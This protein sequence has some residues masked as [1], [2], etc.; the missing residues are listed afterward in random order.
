MARRNLRIQEFDVST[1]SNGASRVLCGQLGCRSFQV[2]AG[3]DDAMQ[4][5]LWK[6]SKPESLLSLPGHSSAITSVAFSSEEIELYSGSFG[7]TV[8]VWDLN[9]QKAVSS[10]KGHLSACTTLSAYPNEGQTYLVTGSSDCNIKFW[11]LRRKACIQTF[12]GHRGNVNVVSFSPDS[13][14]IA[15]GGADGTVKIWDLSTSKKLCDF[16]INDSPVTCLQFNPQNL[17]MSSGHQDRTVQH[18]DLENFGHIS[19]TTPEANPIQR[20]C[21]ETSEG[22]MLFTAANDSLKLWDIE[23]GELY[24]SIESSWKGVVDLAINEKDN[25]LAGLCV[26]NSSFS[27]WSTDLSQV[28]YDTPRIEEQKV[29]PI[30]V[31]PK[32]R[33]KVEMGASFV[34]ARSNAPI[35]LNFQEF[36]PKV[37]AESSNDSKILSEIDENHDRIL[38]V[39]KRRT[40]SINLVLNWW[41]GGNMSATINALNMMND[42]SVRADVLRYC[43]TDCRL[44][45]LSL[46]HCASILPLAKSLIDSKYE[47]Y[48]RTGMLVVSTLLKQFRSLITSTLTVPVMMG[49]D[50]A[51][52]ERIKKCESCLAAFKSVNESQGLEKNSKRENPTGEAGKELKRNLE[53]FIGESKR[54]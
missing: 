23:N 32:K 4:V 28:S 9:A 13:R 36:M 22:R 41:L 47:A 50:L 48:I 17:S 52:E 42:I 38:T 27:L 14:W 45:C 54:M 18:W 46:E 44:D 49:V 39:I 20:I 11:D 51:K 37:E 35:G 29:N 21:F 30:E 2:V 25:I 16:S 1:N 5:R 6:I 40:E 31:R 43:F 3:G 8:I 53:T 15:S 26:N 7:G 33:E 19:Q 10:L 24:D 12:K 34:E